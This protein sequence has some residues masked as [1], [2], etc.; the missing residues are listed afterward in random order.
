MHTPPADDPTEGELPWEGQLNFK[1]QNSRRASSRRRS[2]LIAVLPL[3]LFSTK[4]PGCV[5]AGDATAPASFFSPPVPRLWQLCSSDN[6]VVPGST[7][8]PSRSGVQLFLPQECEITR[9]TRLGEFPPD[10]EFNLPEKRMISCPH[11]SL[12]VALLVR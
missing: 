12:A 9:R 4:N 5:Q 6:S 1:F 3:F 2:N 8:W 10:C 11:F 7:C